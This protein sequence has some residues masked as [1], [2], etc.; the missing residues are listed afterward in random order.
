[1]AVATECKCDYCGVI[2]PDHQI[3]ESKHMLSCLTCRNNVRMLW[4]QAR[5]QNTT[6]KIAALE[7]NEISKFKDM[8]RDFGKERE[9]QIHECY[10]Y[11]R[12][13]KTR[14]NSDATHARGCCASASR[15]VSVQF[16]L[17]FRSRILDHDA[18]RGGR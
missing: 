8:V 5:Q 15:E 4:R 7:R 16:D 1:M 6:A 14:M 11:G 17:S 10:G 13:M 3:A 2:G 18:R 9:S 12:M